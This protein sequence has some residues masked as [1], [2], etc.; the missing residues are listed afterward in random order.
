MNKKVWSFAVSIVSILLLHSF[1]LEAAGTTLSLRERRKTIDSKI[2]ILE[3][4][5]SAA[6]LNEEKLFDRKTAIQSKTDEIFQEKTAKE[7][8]RDLTYIEGD[9]QTLQVEIAESLELRS[10]DLIGIFARAYYLNKDKDRPIHPAKREKIQRYFEMAKKEKFS[11]Q[12]YLRMN[13]PNL[14]ILSLKRSILYSFYSFQES[15]TDIPNQYHSAYSY[16]MKSSP[17][18][19]KDKMADGGNHGRNED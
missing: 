8:T 19:P 15:E 7:Q 12:K 3:E 6:I 5:E 14:A 9:L 17:I 10:E 16:W 4:I 2:R 13:N 1:L 11:A 18:F